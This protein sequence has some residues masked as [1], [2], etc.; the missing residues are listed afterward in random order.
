MYND[1]HKLKLR[2]GG[3]R[4][5]G[6][7]GLRESR[8]LVARSLNTDER[9]RPAASSLLFARFGASLAEESMRPTY[10]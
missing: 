3:G 8:K 9:V 6:K 7:A 4:G 10:L 1:N 5:I 2:A